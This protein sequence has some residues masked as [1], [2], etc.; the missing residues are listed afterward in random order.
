MDPPLSRE[1]NNS[2]TSSGLTPCATIHGLVKRVRLALSAHSDLLG[3]V[4]LPGFQPAQGKS[5]ALRERHVLVV[6]CPRPVVYE[7]TLHF[8]FFSW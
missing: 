2:S 4:L 8:D 5:A 7:R 1:I 6:I 3:L